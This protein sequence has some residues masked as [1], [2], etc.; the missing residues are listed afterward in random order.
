MEDAILRMIIERNDLKEDESFLFTWRIIEMIPDGGG[1][2]DNEGEELGIKKAILPFLLRG[3]QKGEK[4]APQWII[5]A[6]REWTKAGLNKEPLFW[7]ESYCCKFIDW[8]FQNRE[9]VRAF[10]VDED[11][12]KGDEI[13][14]DGPDE[15]MIEY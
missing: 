10:F 4:P 15:S 8:V 9:G 12:S 3:D 14:P 11:G 2:V 5:D 1:I 13:S 6:A 7:G